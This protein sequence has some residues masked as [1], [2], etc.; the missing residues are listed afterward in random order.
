MEKIYELLFV[1][2]EHYITIKKNNGGYPTK[3]SSP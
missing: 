2:N 1:P 3:I